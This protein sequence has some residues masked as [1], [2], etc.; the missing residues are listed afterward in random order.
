MVALGSFTYKDRRNIPGNSHVISYANQS[1]KR[2]L[3]INTD[4]SFIDYGDSD[5]E[6]MHITEGVPDKE[7]AFEIA[8]NWLPKLNVDYS[9]LVKKANGD[10]RI[11]FSE[12][13]TMFYKGSGTPAYA[14]NI[15]M[16]DVTFKR[17]L[18]G[19]EM[20]GG[21]ARGGC[22]IEIGHHAKIYRLLLSWRKYKRDE[23]YPVA[24]S[25]ELMNWIRKGK[26]VWYPAPDSHITDL[27]S[28]RKLAIT[29]VTPYY[30]SDAYGAED[31]PQDWAI[32]FAEMEATVDNGGTNMGVRID[33]P[34]IDEAKL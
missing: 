2:W 25:E 27:S 28:V 30:Y 29:K 34:I 7:R 11:Y 26:A 33:C 8:T 4:W 5:A 10:M 6:N 32:P 12:E 21:S 15:S 22:D 19:V 14:T 17:A 13:A 23:L 31:K 20:S 3:L 18:D 24:T 16:C 9:Q 1:R